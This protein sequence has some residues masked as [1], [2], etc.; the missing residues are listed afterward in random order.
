MLVNVARPMIAD[1]I[2]FLIF[3]PQFSSAQAASQE[4][5]GP[6]APRVLFAALAA[7]LRCPNDVAFRK[8]R[9]GEGAIASTRGACA[10]QNESLRL[11]DS[12][13]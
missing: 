8:V 4:T 11:S 10:C 9:D 6:H 1:Q 2:V 3:M 12:F 5:V 7:N 13:E